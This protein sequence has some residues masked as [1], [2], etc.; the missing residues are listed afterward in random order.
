[1][2]KHLPLIVLFL[3]FFIAADAQTHADSMSKHPS[4]TLSKFPSADAVKKALFDSLKKAAPVMDTSVK[5]LPKV[6]VK[7]VK[8]DSATKRITHPKIVKRGPGPLVISHSTVKTLSDAKYNTLRKGGDFDD[9]ALTAVL[10]HYPSPDSALKYK[11]QIGLNPGQITKL[12]EISE[13]LH[14]KRIEMGDNIIKNEKTLDTLFKTKQ[15]EDGNIIFYTT[16][17]GLYLGEIRNAVLQACYK[18][19]DILSDVQIRKLESLQKQ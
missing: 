7:P 17:Y 2:L 11:V 5:P 14:R 16:R 1:M 15:A 12:K 3:L 9:M 6:K 4:D 13:G 10:N 19:R 18:T 8:V